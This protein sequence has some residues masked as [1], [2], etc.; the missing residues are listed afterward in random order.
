MSQVSDPAAVTPTAETTITVTLPDGSQRTLPQGATALDLAKSIGAGLA[1]A[2]VAASITP[3]LTDADRLAC[4]A[5]QH[6][7]PLIIDFTVPLPNGAQVRLLT[8]KDPE[9]LDVVRHSAAH[10]MAQAVQRLWP[11]AKIALGPAVEQG[12]YYDFSIPDHQITPEDFPSIEAEMAKIASE[13]QRFMREYIGDS[14]AIDAFLAQC[15]AQ[16]ERFKADV[17]QKYR[18]NDPTLYRCI[19][20]ESGETV[21]FDV[22]EGPHI[23][24]TSYLK[25]F[26][27]LSVAGAYWRGDENNEQLQRL[28]ATAFWTQADLVA[29]LA[30]REEAERRDHRK[31]AKELDLFSI[32]E[33]IGPGLILWHP[34][35]SVVR[36]QLEAFLKKTLR[37]YNYQSVYTP[38]L[39]KRDLWDISGHTS[40]YLENMFTL[41]IEGQQYLLKPMNCPM[42]TMIFK[43]N[44][45]SYRD[46]PIKIAELGTVYRYEKSGVMHGLNR[47]RG[48][49][50]D[51]AHIFCRPDQITE[52]ITELIG[53]VDGIFQR[54]GMRFAQVELSTR[55]EQYVGELA[56]WDTAEAALKSA[57][58]NYGLAYE[59]NEGDGAFYGP[60]IDFK[61]KDAIG[62]TWQCSTIQLD[63]N[64][65]ERFNLRFKDSDGSE[66]RP[67]MIH[68]AIFGSLERFAGILIEHYVGAFP[69]WLAPTQ[70]IVLPISDRHEAYAEQVAQAL[71]AQDLRVKVDASSETIN[72]KVRKA[73]LLKI[74]YMLVV[75]DKELEAQSVAVRAK[76][77]SADQKKPV[78]MPLTELVAG[79]TKEVASYGEQMVIAS[80]EQTAVS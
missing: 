25:A 31:L 40:H 38:H 29:F 39:A 72:N 74:P 51:D 27:I 77:A 78:V 65:P 47:V 68:R 7:E 3:P 64:L 21:W 63:F 49:T 44:L 35:L 23:P 76:H 62:R 28:Y 36:E 56:N 32:K 73:E 4:P 17:V 54:F 14:A 30:Q 69:A 79:L 41:D 67:I 66:K 18:D 19:H 70:A 59:I 13:K 6:A 50:Q 57:L 75:G 2:V 11:S 60:K 52:Q 48:F 26:K 58:D 42:H 37:Q 43:S 22:C 9:S 46:L 45:H 16:G 61:F 71:R 15:T 53:L 33:E 8:A 55:P 12:F 5:H 1:K 10:I 20:P 34:N 80:T 24:D